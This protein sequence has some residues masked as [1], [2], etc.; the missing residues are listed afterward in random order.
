MNKKKYIAYGMIRIN[1]TFKIKNLFK[2]N[3]KQGVKTCN[4]LQLM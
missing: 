2:L 3:K 1:K 4:K